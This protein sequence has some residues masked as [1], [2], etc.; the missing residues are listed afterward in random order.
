M[1]ITFRINYKTEWGQ[2]VW[3]A[4]SV[5]AL[6]SWDIQNAIPMLYV[7]NGEWEATISFKSVKNFEYK[8]LIKN[9][10]YSLFWEGGKNRNF[11]PE[12]FTSAEIRDFWRLQINDESV[13]FSSVFTGV[14]FKRDQ[15]E[16]KNGKNA[17]ALL[18]FTI[19]APRVAPDQVMG[20]I[21]NNKKLGLWDK[22]LIMDD[23]NYPNWTLDIDTEEV[24]FPIEYKYVIV[25][26]KTG[27]IK[28]WE[29]GKERS[30]PS[31]DTEA[32]KSIYI[33]N[34]ENFRYSS[35]KWKG[36]GVAVPV[37]SLRSEDSFGV[38]EFNDLKK[39]VDWAKRT[40]IKI[41]QVLPVNETIATHSWLDSYPYK[42]I[43]V[44]AL[45]PMY[46]NPEKMGL[47]S[48]EKLMDEFEV[49]KDLLNANT[50]V[51]YVEVMQVKSRYYKLIFD[52][53]WDE[54]KES[55]SY[56]EFF[57]RNKEWLEDYA[58]FCFLRDQYK[59]PN[60]REWGAWAEYKPSKIKKLVDPASSHFE[61]IAV[62]YF[63]QY[64]LD[65]QLREAIEY[66]HASG[67]AFK[68][69]IPIGISPNSIEAWTK[70]NLFNLNGQAGAPPDDFSVLGQ[71]WGF[72]TYNWE[73]MAEDD[74]SWWRKRLNALSNYFDAYRI[75]HILGFF[76]IWE[77]PK[78]AT[79]GLL[80]YFRPGLPLLPEEIIDRGIYFDSERFTKPYIRGHFLHEI[81]GEFTPEVKKQY[82]TEKGEN[83]YVLKPAFDTQRKIYDHFTPDGDDTK[84]DAK[85]TIIRD[86]LI[87]LL[88]EVLFIQ[89][90]YCSYPAYHPRIAFHDTNSFNE[91][92]QETKY[93]LDDLYIDFFYKRHEDFWKV[94]AFMKLPALINAT[95]MLVCG[96]D[97][98]MVPDCV[99]EVMRTLNILSL[100]VQRMP[101]NPKVEFGHP[102]D[103]PYLSVCTTSTHDM[104]T[105]RGWWEENREN[106]QRF[107]RHILGHNDQAPYF[108]EPWICK[109]IINQHLHSPAMLAIFPIQDLLAMDG[110]LRWDET[111]KE[112]I[113]IPSDEKNKWCYRMILSLEKLLEADEF[114]NLI[115]SMIHMSGR[116]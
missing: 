26:R 101:K 41:I 39:L 58:A 89:D 71:N 5:K 102:A 92:D 64:H 31:I 55:E 50:I 45:H 18:R 53:N 72:P 88:D 78:E 13:L 49:A 108:A 103:A 37:F 47:L 20:I 63:I 68:G 4:G 105:I 62:H 17:S 52:Q 6:G 98:G 12:E 32:K 77:I 114:N 56:K 29:E 90:P 74:F 36:T 85:S 28:I 57:S 15:S 8:Y 24:H 115:Q 48:D 96:E 100:E 81:F 61:H 33:H 42:A 19:P 66:G 107:Y 54:V 113:N 97:L 11:D 80:G 82:L 116:E 46:L 93:R 40:G 99:P 104:S 76:R 1:K 14:L 69:D 25:D 94:E 112:R 10:D 23:S 51:D 3:I 79:H 21:G 111:S 109:E 87:S 106:T 34:D 110:N 75:D 43:S 35:G 65:L 84:V 2:G 22:P 59:T 86:G 30:V 16:V 38:G 7:G 70:P 83:S 73:V 9:G 95:N 27:A 44:F 60:F 67:V 91:L